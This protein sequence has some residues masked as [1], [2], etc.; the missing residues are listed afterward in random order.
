MWYITNP[1]EA[2]RV[3]IRERGSS[4]AAIARELG[5]DPSAVTHVAKQNHK[6]ERILAALAR[7]ADMT[8]DMTLEELQAPTSEAKK[9]ADAEKE[10]DMSS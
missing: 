6:S 5:V 4:F 8:L 1:Y 7:H 10:T 2:M 9:S 3:R